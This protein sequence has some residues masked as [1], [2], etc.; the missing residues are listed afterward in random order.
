MPAQNEKNEVNPVAAAWRFGGLEWIFP[1]RCAVCGSVI[2][3][4]EVFCADCEKK[5]PHCPREFLL[6]SKTDGLNSPCIALFA[7]EGELRSAVL[8]FKF[9]GFRGASRGFGI[10]MAQAVQGRVDMDFV[11]TFVPM[12]RS[13]RLERGYNQ[14]KLLAQEVASQLSLPCA[15]L[16]KKTRVTAQQHTLSREKRRENAHGAFAAEK[17]AAGKNI[18]LCDDIVTTGETL[19]E[20]VRV[21]RA[22]GAKSVIC[23]VIAYAGVEIGKKID[24]NNST[25]N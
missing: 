7:Y 8:A 9:R 2:P 25:G 6:R 24:Y 3:R 18:V 10:Q 16:L 19:R 15:P 14:A 17:E 13:R 22:A 21:L 20:C 4:T 12:D 11:V 5:F 1:P 23:A